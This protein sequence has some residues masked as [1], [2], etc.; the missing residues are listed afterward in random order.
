MVP[1]VGLAMVRLA[2]HPS[3]SLERCV[4]QSKGTG[5]FFPEVLCP[6]CFSQKEAK[7][8][9]LLLGVIKDK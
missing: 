4:T 7:M 3:G 8:L 2:P 1:G 9:A 5:S 6:P